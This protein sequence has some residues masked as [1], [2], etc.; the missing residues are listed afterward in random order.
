MCGDLHKRREAARKS[1]PK[2]AFATVARGAACGLLR[3]LAM[4]SLAMNSASFSGSKLW[5]LSLLLMAAPLSGCIA[6]TED[7]VDGDAEEVIE[8]D[9]A[10]LEPG[11][12]GGACVASP[13][14]CK[15][16][17]SGGNVVD[18]SKEGLWAVEDAPVVDGN[19]DM[20]GMN[21]RD[22]LRF[23]HGQTR[24]MND[25]T[26]VFARSTS[27]GSTGWFPIDKVLGEQSLREKVGEVNAKGAGL[28]KMAC[29]SVRDAHDAGLV[30]KK[31]VYDSQETHERAGDYL[32]LP[33]ANGGR[34]VNLAFSVPGFA[35]G[36]P[37]VD[38][39]PAGTRFQRLDVPTDS[40]KPSID[41]PLWVEDSAGRYRKQS[42]VM[43]FVYGY[44][45]AKTG[46]KRYGWM[47]YD[48]LAQAS[49]CL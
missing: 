33:R 23:N 21:T 37:G 39:F 20:M 8:N 12:N 34:Y 3:C 42:G 27:V 45:T 31:V 16:R 44:V 4:N 15:L 1:G 19:G 43:K 14:N 18:N 7:D 30:E 47:A 40:G 29:Y 13:Y 48:A 26:Y 35:L 25:T 46:T 49:G 38:I 24:R 32:P 11:V 36:A 9:E 17:V 6:A 2:Q 41:V 22:H 28:G 10:A 5:V